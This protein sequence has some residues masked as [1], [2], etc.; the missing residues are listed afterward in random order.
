MKQFYER[1]RLPMPPLSSP[2]ATPGWGQADENTAR[3]FLVR[4]VSNYPYN[5]LISCIYDLA[6]GRAGWDNFLDT[7]AAAFPGCAIMVSGDDLVTGRNLVFAQRGLS[8]SAAAAYVTH[9][10]RLNPW[11][12]A[13]GNWPPGHLYQDEDLAE[14]GQAL[15][16]PYYTEWLGRQGRFDAAT[17]FVVLRSGARQ[18]AIELRYG[19]E[20]ERLVRDRAGT[21]LGDAAFHFH[22]A[23]E[24]ERAAKDYLGNVVDDLAF[25]VFLLGADMR[26]VYANHHADALRRSGTG[27]F[28]GDRAVLRATDGVVDSHLR[29]FVSRAA[30][31]RSSTSI[32][33][34]DSPNGRYFAIARPVV[35]AS[36]ATYQLHEALFDSG[37]ITMLIVHGASGMPALPADMLWRAFGLTE[38]ETELAEAMLGGGTVA[39]YA[40]ARLVSKQTLRNQLVGLMRKTG[41]HR[42]A[43]LVGLLTRLALTSA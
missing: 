36:E 26:V 29:D 40:Q 13:L 22:H 4:R 18:L 27:P 31:R 20:D 14:R 6:R 10:A 38:A 23:L 42:Q 16:S 43:E 21:I 34:F 32:F 2:P 25:P 24:S 35:S 15:D 30:A 37:P 5:S 17:G 12:E 28:L 41:T 39:E 8:P 7:L 1:G 11:R 19:V 3:H 9:Y 33:A